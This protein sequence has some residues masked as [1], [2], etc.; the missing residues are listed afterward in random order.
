MSSQMARTTTRTLTPRGGR[1]SCMA[2]GRGARGAN[3][4]GGIRPCVPVPPIASN[5][6]SLFFRAAPPFGLAVFTMLGAFDC[7]ALDCI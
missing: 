3:L 2:G 7:M 1:G 6:H 5:C 4:P